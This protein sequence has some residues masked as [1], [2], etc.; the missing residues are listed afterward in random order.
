MPL[1]HRGI[2]R[3]IV[4]RLGPWFDPR[5]R[6]P[7]VLLA[8]V[9]LGIFLAPLAA[10]VAWAIV[11]EVPKPVRRAAGQSAMVAAI[12]L[13]LVRLGRVRAGDR[14]PGPPED[15]P[16]TAT[17]RWMPW[18]LRLAVASLA[19]P[20]LANPDHLGFADWDFVLDKY[21]AARRTIAIWRQFPWW[22]PW[23]R[24]GFPLAAEPQIGAV[25]IAT[26]MILAFGTGV[27]LRI[28]AI[29]CI[30]IAVEGAYRLGWLWLREPW[31][32]AVVGL[33]YGLNGAVLVNTADGYII[34]MSYGCLPWLACHAF[35]IGE[36]AE[37]GAWLGF[38]A[39]FAV[40][41]GIQ[42]LTLYAVV[43]AGAIGLRAVMVPLPG[44]RVTVFRSTL[45][46]AGVF[47][48]LC[49]WRLATVIPVLLEDRRERVTYWD[50]SLT[51]FLYALINRPLRDWPVRL[52]GEHW[53]TYVSLTSYV[54]VVV[55]VLVVVS[56][57]GGWR[58]WHTLIV[59]TAWLAIGSTEWYHPSYWLASWPII[60][61][62]H[63]VTRWRFVA[64]LGIGLA[65]GSVVARW[66]AS[67][68][69]ILAVAAAAV[70]PVIGADYLAI[71]YEQLPIA[72]SV[73][74]GSGAFPGPPVGEVVNVLQ[75]EGY[76]CVL[77][78][79]GVIR[80]YEP[81][82]SYRRGSPTLRMARE[83]PGYRGES[84]TADGPV[85]PAFWS[86]N[87]IVFR[88]RPGEEVFINQ[89]P[90]SW[91]LVNGRRI[92][93]GLRCAEPMVPFAVR[94][95]DSG[96]LELRIDPPGLGVG[97]VL[98]LAGAGLVIAVLVVGKRGPD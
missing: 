7:L 45:A 78:G 61:M 67:G 42:Y 84:W 46:A 10:E 56:L 30:G 62:A 22:N 64:M 35:R 5:S 70:P 29:V 34:A 58:W 15:E 95:D 28:A 55:A 1:D 18:A 31:A 82:I 27:G 94:A 90:G 9:S 89:N 96:R 63:A 60:G 16:V 77:R 73:P 2:V 14:W 86:P 26:P 4:R 53:A 19:I 83:Q 52:F 88:V 51:G 92:F 21:E 11:L 80:G 33:V 75:G 54:G 8:A 85:R 6:R 66:R 65:S 72:F 48:V 93:A 37:Q 24:G 3:G 23:C 68:V 81:M 13:G 76:R 59:L 50:E 38:W 39:A 36:G 25:S 32:A 74:P 47:L 87:R 49:G 71:G 17:G 44:R 12:A 97:L 91:W 43:L 98:H 79:Y 41:N 69:R 40:L 57:A 20:M